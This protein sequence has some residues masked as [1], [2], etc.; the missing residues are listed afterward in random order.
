MNLINTLSFIIFLRI[1]ESD[2]YLSFII[3]LRINKS[4]KYTFI[5]QKIKDPRK[6]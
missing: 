5:F 1:N 4:D 6:K 3:F 2:K